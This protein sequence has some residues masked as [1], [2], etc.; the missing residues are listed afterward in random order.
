[1]Y[2]SIKH[3]VWLCVFY[4]VTQII[5]LRDIL[6]LSFYTQPWFLKAFYFEI[7]INSHEVA[8]L[9]QTVSRTPHPASLNGNILYN[10]S[11]VSKPV[12][13]CVEYC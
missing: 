6:R 12:N 10:Y 5:S 7:V 11:T 9:G 2:L 3:I 8:K 13:R 4:I 1:M